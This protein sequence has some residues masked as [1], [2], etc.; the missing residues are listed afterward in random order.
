MTFYYIN[1]LRRQ[2]PPIAATNDNR[3]AY[4]ATVFI[5]ETF[6]KGHFIGVEGIIIQVF[7]KTGVQHGE[8]LTGSKDFI[9]I[10][11]EQEGQ[12]RILTEIDY[13]IHTS[14]PILADINHTVKVYIF[15]R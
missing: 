14:P 13:F 1:D 5:G 11:P 4:A 3:S 6:N 9:L 10:I 2:K 8:S 12:V 7:S 15:T